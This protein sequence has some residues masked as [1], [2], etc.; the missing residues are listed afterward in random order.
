MPFVQQT[1]RPFTHEDVLAISPGQNGVYGILKQ[2]SWIYVGKA[3]LRERLLDH[4]NGDNPCILRETPT[5]WVGE[6]V[7]GDPSDREKQ[8]ILELDPVCNK[9]LG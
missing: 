2:G 9:R 8:L 7:Q 6:V 4:L 5:H 3:D 1:S